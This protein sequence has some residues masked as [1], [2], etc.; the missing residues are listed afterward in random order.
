MTDPRF[1]QIESHRPYLVRYA[2]SQL[3]DSQLAEEAVQEALLSAL[4][5]LSNFEGKSSLR[6]WLTS[7]LR[8]KVIDL[9][10]RAVSDRTHL[11]PTDFAAETGDDAWLDDL[12]DETGH[13]RVAPNA[14]SNPEA[15]LEQRRFWE[16]FERCLDKLPA[17][18]GRVFF[19]REIA[20][21]ETETICKEEGITASNCWVILHRAR[22]SLR[23]CLEMNWFGNEAEIR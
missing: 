17:A 2:L 7:I 14:W 1:A 8:F 23:A 16:T 20:G 5:S 19:K 15:A 6:T 11:E 3:R 22:L 18:G 12:F 9:Q 13:W 10:R 4:E 21:E